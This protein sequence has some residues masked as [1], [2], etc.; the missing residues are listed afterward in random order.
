ML[1]S[2]GIRFISLPKYSQPMVPL[3]ISATAGNFIK[4]EVRTIEVKL[5][6][7]MNRDPLLVR[8]SSGSNT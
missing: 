4:L 6:G 5:A 3:L 2:L 8:H 7:L 1:H